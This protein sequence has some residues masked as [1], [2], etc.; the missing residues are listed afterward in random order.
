MK[1]FVLG[2]PA[3]S[4]VLYFIAAIANSP[5]VSGSGGKTFTF[6]E[7]AA[8]KRSAE[9]QTFLPKT[10]YEYIDGAA[11]LYLAYDFQELKVAEYLN[12]RKASVTL[13]LYRHESPNDAFGIYSQERFPDANYLNIGAEGY[14][15]KNILNF[16]AGSHYVKI[17]S[18]HTGAEHPEVLQAFGKKIAENLGEKGGL[19]SVLSS[20]P[21]AGKI[22][23]SEKFIRRNFLGYSFLGSAFTT[24]YN[25][26]GKQFKLFLMDFGDRNECRNVVQKYPQQ[27]G[28]PNNEVTEGRYTLTDPHHGVVDLYWKG[29]HISGVLDLAEPELRSKYLK[30]FEERLG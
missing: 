24:D 1:S 15:D 29:T 20:F 30:D 7:M 19:P 26:S 16:V 2:I 21:M 4:V 5:A 8:W 23:H 12:D 18:Y 10:L 25:L 11:D 27:I 9:I 3:S 17:T 6:P 28:R 14:I 22:S 13:E